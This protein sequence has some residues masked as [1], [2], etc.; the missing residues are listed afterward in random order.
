MSIDWF[1]IAAQAFN[2]LLLIWLMK[3][4]LYKPILKAIDAR[5]EKIAE[6][7]AEADRKEAAAQAEHQE[8]LQKNEAFDRQRA[9]L[10]SQA[11]SEVETKR[12]RLLDEAGKEADDLREKRQEMLLRD[13]QRLDKAIGLRTQEE[14]FA[15]ARKALADLSSDSLEERVCTVFIRRLREMDKDEKEGLAEALGTQAGTVLVNSAF[16]LS[17]AQRD[18]IQSALGEIFQTEIRLQY[19]TV[20]ELIGGIEFVANGH[21]ISWNI[22]DYIASLEKGVGELIKEGRS[23]QQ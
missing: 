16:D 7:L 17:Q 11:T 9:E 22:A 8:F 19:K 20:P 23:S 12:L 5:E 21:K 1:T 15:I 2:F 10:L 4:F 6:K 13:A 14:V 3:R 18:D